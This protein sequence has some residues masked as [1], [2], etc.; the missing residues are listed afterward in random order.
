MAQPSRRPT[1]LRALAFE[2]LED[3]QPLSCSNVADPSAPLTGSGNRSLFSQTNCPT[4][5]TAVAAPATAAGSPSS[6]AV[7]SSRLVLSWPAAGATVSPGNVTLQW[8]RPAGFTGEFLV[9][10]EEGNWG[11][12]RA[13]GMTHVCNSYYACT[14]TRG[15]SLTLPVRDNTEYRWFVNIPGGP[16]AQATF[17]TQQVRRTVPAAPQVRIASPPD[18]SF[19]TSQSV[20]LRFEP[21]A[22]Y[23]G[24][25]L[26]VMRDEKWNGTQAPGFNHYCRTEYLCVAT[27]QSSLQVPVTPGAS[28]T[29]TVMA[30]GHAAARARFMVKGVRPRAIPPTAPLDSLAVPE[31]VGDRYRCTAVAPYANEGVDVS[32]IL[33]QCLDKTPAGATI[34]F[35][36]GNYYL[37]KQVRATRRLTLTSVGKRPGDPACDDKAGDCAAWIA[38]SALN[39]SGGLLFAS[40]IGGVRHMILDGNKAGREGSAAFAACQTN[41]S[42][43]FNA[44]IY[45]DDITV[46]GNVIKNAVCGAGL[47]MGRGHKNAVIRNNVIKDNGF[48]QRSRLW[49]D[50]LTV[51]DLSHSQIVDNLFVD[52]TDIDL[53]LGGCR[54]CTIQGNQIRHTN[55]ARNG[56]FVGL[57]LYRWP[58]TSGDYSGSDISRNVIDGGLGSQIGTGIYVG[59]DGWSNTRVLGLSPGRTTAA[60]LHDNVVRNTMS[61]LYVAAQDFTIHRNQFVNTSGRTF[62]GSCGTISSAAPVLISDT[63]Q[64]IN[65]LGEDSAPAT[66]R[67]FARATWR[68]CIPNWPF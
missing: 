58:D 36:A 19:L 60:N 29:W 64:R 18:G 63:A 14:M 16:S 31:R 22:G 20:N 62:R 7:P 43:G 2:P 53:I 37:N 47:V 48:H 39:Q 68:Q 46:E 10:V 6:Q 49:A 24:Q 5:T 15:S 50:G 52:N 33:Q 44:L 4:A 51:A 21:A 17:R 11:G 28:Y 41:N 54:D 35:P 23:Q 1:A 34:E 66:F 45:S 57:M 32:P 55:D 59:S 30:S 3:R 13:P 38:T 56:A 26:V 8:A 61:G 25:Y 27:P 65:F 67:Q 9:R 40:Q 12:R 42:V